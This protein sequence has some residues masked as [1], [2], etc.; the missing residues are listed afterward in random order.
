[1]M[2][3]EAEL[4]ITDVA[5]IISNDDDAYETVWQTYIRRKVDVWVVEY[6]PMLTSVCQTACRR[7]NIES[8]V[9][10]MINDCVVEAYRYAKNYKPLP[11]VRFNSYLVAYFKLYP[12]RRDVIARYKKSSGTSLDAIE[13]DIQAKQEIS[14]SDEYRSASELLEGLPTLDRTYLVLKF[15]SGFNNCEIARILNTNEGV[16]RYQLKRI[17]G[18]IKVRGDGK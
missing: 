6:L 11:N 1:M 2:Q 3:Q 9:D 14:T 5:F 7:F 4:D 17:L 10:D 13:I 8:C 15:V 12:T 16:V 18:K